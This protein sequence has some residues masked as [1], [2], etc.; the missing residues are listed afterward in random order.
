[1]SGKLIPYLN[2]V[3]HPLVYRNPLPQPI[4]LVAPLSL[5]DSPMELARQPRQM[6]PPYPQPLPPHMQSHPRSN[7]TENYSHMMSS[8]PHTMCAFPE[9]PV[10]S[11]YCMPAP[12]NQ[13]NGQKYQTIVYAYGQSRPYMM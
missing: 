7:M 5:E 4:P 2:P 9:P 6:T 11:V 10:R 12:Y 3:D 8:Q 1:M 13:I